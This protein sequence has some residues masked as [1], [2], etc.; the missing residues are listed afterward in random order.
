VSPG[1]PEEVARAAWPNLVIDPAQ[2]AVYLAERGDPTDPD[3]VTDLYLA[4]GCV[5]G[6]PAAITYL[7][8]VHLSRVATFLARIDT[9]REFVD[10]VRQLVREQLLVGRNAS[11]PAILDYSGRGPLE[12][13]VSVSTQRIAL[14]L[15]RSRKVHADVEDDLVVTPSDPELDYVRFVSQREFAASLAAALAAA[16]PHERNVLRLHFVE[17]LTT[18]EIG[19]LFKAHRATI[20]RQIDECQDT[21]LKRVRRDLRERLALTDSQLDTLLRAG[22]ESVEL[23]L[24]SLL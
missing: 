19:K 12:R 16:T 5:A 13:W 24:S 15:L 18:T 8:T 21:L 3:R 6:D 4:C 11:R 17:G 22:R 14:N 20:R 10:E 23:S 1:A 9:R 7:E 2:L